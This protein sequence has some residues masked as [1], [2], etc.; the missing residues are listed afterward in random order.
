MEP[1]VSQYKLEIQMIVFFFLGEGVFHNHSNNREEFCKFLEDGSQIPEVFFWSPLR[2]AYCD[3][4]L[5]RK[6]LLYWL[7]PVM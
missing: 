2:L 3:G 4:F 5:I 7:M 6:Q 1:T